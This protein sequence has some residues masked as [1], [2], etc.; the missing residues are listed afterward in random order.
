MEN[1]ND[2]FALMTKMYSELQKTNEK[3]DTVHKELK[4]EINHLQ[5][6]VSKNSILLEKVDSNVKLLAE[7]NESLREQIGRSSSEDKRTISEQINVIEL[8]VTSTSKDVKFIKHKVLNT[9]EDVFA[10]QDHLKI[11]K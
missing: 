9:E 5:K 2:L 7:G 8:A 4:C 3:I 1:N 6:E 10:I 11:I